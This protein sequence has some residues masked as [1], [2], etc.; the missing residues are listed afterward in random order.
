MTP[1]VAFHLQVGDKLAYTCRLLRKA[2]VSGARLVV[3]GEPAT[4]N[5][6]DADLWTFSAT[7]FLPHCQASAGSSV[8]KRSKVILSPNSAVLASADMV[9]VNLG[10][11][12]PAG[13]DAYSRVIEVVSDDATDL[14]LARKRWK[15]YASAGCTLTKHDRGMALA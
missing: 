7:D 6:L 13:F 10:T 12:L 11:D 5:Q 15:L 4:L 3:T 8:L 2:V 1:A 9:L 14:A